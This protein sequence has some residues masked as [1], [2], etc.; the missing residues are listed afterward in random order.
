ADT[1]LP[2]QV[3][4]AAAVG[5]PDALT[6][7]VG[8]RTT[9]RRKVV[10]DFGPGQPGPVVVYLDRPGF[11]VDHDL[12]PRCRQL[13]L[14][15][16]LRE[17]GTASDRVVR[18]LDHLTQKHVRVGVQILRQELDKAL[19]PNLE[20]TF[21]ARHGRSSHLPARVAANPNSTSE[22]TSHPREAPVQI[23][24][25]PRWRCEPVA[26]LTSASHHGHQV[27][28]PGSAARPDLA[29]AGPDVVVAHRDRACEA[30]VVVEVP[31]APA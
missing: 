18:V 25:P 13:C 12:D 4:R 22:P 7:L 23:R 17:L 5:L 30:A 21:L 20:A 26:G 27:V 1:E 9:D 10:V 6:Q 15:A 8:A 31:P 2:D 3:H 11:A 16:L 24:A 29:G 14:P 19:Q 28:W